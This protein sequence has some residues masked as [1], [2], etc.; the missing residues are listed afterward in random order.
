MGKLPNFSLFLYLT[1]VLSSQAQFLCTPCTGLLGPLALWL[2]LKQF[3]E[4]VLR[5][6][7]SLLTSARFL[8]F[9]HQVYFSSS[10]R[11]KRLTVEKQS[12]I[13]LAAIFTVFLTTTLGLLWLLVPQNVINEAAAVFAIAL[14]F[15]FAA[16]FLLVR[17]NQSSIE[18]LAQKREFGAIKRLLIEK[19]RN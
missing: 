4:L 3:I 18:A 6:L 10:S 12:Q 5:T 11:R 8:C 9:Y 15:S 13:L 19:P 1:P 14:A 16:I 7:D 17:S 2:R